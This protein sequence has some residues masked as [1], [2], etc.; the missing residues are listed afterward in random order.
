MIR[1]VPFVTADARQRVAV[2]RANLEVVW[3]A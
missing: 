3:V 1:R 2:E